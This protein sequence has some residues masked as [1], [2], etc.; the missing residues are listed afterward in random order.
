MADSE[1]LAQAPPP[2]ASPHAVSGTASSGCVEVLL[3]KFY[4]GFLSGI[5]AMS[6]RS[7]SLAALSC[8]LLI[9]GTGCSQISS[10]VSNK[11]SE[12]LE[13]ALTEIEEAQAAITEAEVVEEEEV[14]EQ[15]SQA[16]YIKAAEEASARAQ[17]NAKTAVTRADWTQVNGDWQQAISNL[18][19]VSED[20]AEYGEA[21]TK[22]ASYKNSLAAAAKN[23]VAADQARYT[24]LTTSPINDAP[25]AGTFEAD[26]RQV[27][28]W[29]HKGEFKKVD[30]LLRSSL[31]SNRRTSNGMMYAD[32]VLVNALNGPGVVYMPELMTQLNKWVEAEPKNAMAY[33]VRSYFNQVAVTWTQLRMVR[34]GSRDTS[35]DASS[36][37]LLVSLLDSEVA[38]E[39]E[40]GNRLA[41]IAQLRMAKIISRWG[42]EEGDENF[43]DETFKK[44]NAAMPNS[45]EVAQEKA[46]YLF[47][48]DRSGD[49]ALEYLSPLAA[50]APSGSA[51][52]MLIPMVHFYIGAD[53][54][55]LDE[56]LQKPDVWPEVQKNAEKA[57]AGLPDS[58]LFP[59]WYARMASSTNNDDIASKYIQIAMNNG[60]ESPLVQSFLRMMM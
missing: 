44:A 43:F 2:D 58:A 16:G 31:S 11:A 30:T 12:S 19:A 22:L 57:I 7:I 36:Q 9:S 52:P 18:E 29:L 38:L 20:A 25:K 34:E 21:R 40:S 51:V 32:A 42:E 53:I 49:L 13:G 46:Q 6:S 59:A 28:E 15:I 48:K 47:L 33:T 55:A 3:H 27:R 26:A 10:M 35:P 37:Q 1:I 5:Y 41:L 23:S 45:F 60:S 14:S 8:V 24:T 54:D 4:D 17:N 56:H 39:L 50:A